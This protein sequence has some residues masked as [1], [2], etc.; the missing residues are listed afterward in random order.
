MKW[1]AALII[2]LALAS[3]A[4]AQTTYRVYYRYLGRDA[5]GVPTYREVL[6]PQQ[7]HV[8]QWRVRYEPA[9]GPVYR[10]PIRAVF[11]AACPT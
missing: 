11:S 4:N 3:A 6:V 9:I 5:R 1:I 8:P 10:S 2:T 7:R